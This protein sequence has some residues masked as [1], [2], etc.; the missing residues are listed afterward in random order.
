MARRSIDI[1]N[2]IHLK[3][4]QDA[5]FYH[6]FLEL[7]QIFATCP[8]VSLYCIVK[9][10]SFTVTSYVLRCTVNPAAPSA[11]K[12]SHLSIY[13]SGLSKLVT[14]KNIYVANNYKRKGLLEV[15]SYRCF[16][17]ENK[18]ELQNRNDF[19]QSKLSTKKSC[20]PCSTVL[21]YIS[22]L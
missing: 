9:S 11:C 12:I 14:C 8:T 7:F 1:M 5:T 13:I 19:V 18:I 22:K 15:T 20:F 16:D 6:Q 21:F 4:V 17:I 3:I 2:K 10:I